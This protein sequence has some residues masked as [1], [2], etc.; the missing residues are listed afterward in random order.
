MTKEEIREEVEETMQA[1][2]VA[3]TRLNNLVNRISETGA[4]ATKGAAITLIEFSG[5]ELANQGMGEAWN[6][7]EYFL[8]PEG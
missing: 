6:S 1:L 2:G 5:L 3:H 8:D 7:L 4:A